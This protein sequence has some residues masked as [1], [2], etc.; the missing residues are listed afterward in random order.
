M[1]LFIISD[2]EGG[3]ESIIPYG[4]KLAKHTETGVQILHIIDPRSK[5][6][7]SS[8]YAD[9]K[10]ISPGNKLSH[11]RILQREEN[12]ASFALDKLLSAEA[13]RLNYPLK[14]N[15]DVRSDEVEKG[16]KT[17]LDSDPEPLLVASLD[18]VNSMITSLEEVVGIIMGLDS[19]GLFIPPGHT[20]NEPDNVLLFTD[21]NDT[22]YERIRQ[23]VKWLHPF[24]PIINFLAIAGNKEYMDL[25]LKSVAWKKGVEKFLEPTLTLKT[26]I[27]TSGGDKDTLLDYVRRNDPR[28]VIIPG[29]IIETGIRKVI[30]PGKREKML[31]SFEKPV[32]IY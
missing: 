1:K 6:G 19:P 2:I 31:K 13:S 17:A 10:S 4:L 12:K 8:P 25:E 11:K 15:V 26:T 29:R 5:Q 14:I 30:K 22:D 21:F 20:F 27:L 24:S 18:P 16:I 32:M 23:A 3:S 9:S 28:M 7:V